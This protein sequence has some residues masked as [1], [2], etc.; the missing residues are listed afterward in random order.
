MA[1]MH[2]FPHSIDHERQKYATW[3]CREGDLMAPCRWEGAHRTAAHGQ[4]PPGLTVP[5]PHLSF[6]SAGTLK[7]EVWKENSTYAAATV[8]PGTGPRDKPGR[9]TIE[10]SRFTHLPYRANKCFSSRGK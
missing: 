10:Q 5:Q 9:L 4:P 2:V 8:C 6:R 7:K 1:V 3:S